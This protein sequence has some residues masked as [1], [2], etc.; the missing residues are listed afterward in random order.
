MPVSV[1]SAATSLQVPGRLAPN[2][3]RTAR[4]SAPAQGRLVA[5]HVRIGDLVTSG[6][7]LVTLQSAEA[8]SAR[9]DFSKAVAE[10]NARRTASVYARTAAERARRLLAAKAISAQDVERAEADNQLAQSTL[11]QA[12]AEVSRAR[13]TLAQL[14]VDGAAGAMILRSP[15]SGVVVSREAVPGS[16]VIAGTPM[17]TVTDPLTLWLDVSAPDRMASAFRSGANVKFSVPAYPGEFFQARVQ[18]VGGALDPATRALLVRAV[19]ENPARRLRPE[20][21]ATVWIE[22]GASQTGVSVPDD[23]VQLLEQK[24]V[25]FIAK[26]DGKGG[27]RFERRAVELGA[28]MNGRTQILRGVTAGELVVVNGAFA[29]KAEFARSKMAAG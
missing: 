19:V 5:V 8:A 11:A 20:M 25:V 28:K 18:N 27:A 4:L 1:I 16:V 2:E 17:L 29:V 24:P 9:A 3:D 6:Q 26:P 13:V 14:G 15:L 7:P 22:S 12:Q 23:A 10:L 21:F